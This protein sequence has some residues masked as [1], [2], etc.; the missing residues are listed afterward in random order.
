MGL[1]P[2]IVIFKSIA[3]RTGEER[4]NKAAR[5][6]AKIFAIGYFTFLYRFFRGKVSLKEDNY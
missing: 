6:R 3:I 5:F 4:Y 1:A 2:L